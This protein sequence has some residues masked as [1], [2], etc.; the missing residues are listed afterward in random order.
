MVSQRLSALVTALNL[1]R[2]S[3]NMYPPGHSRI[4]DAVDQAHE[5]VQKSLRGRAELTFARVENT[6]AAGDIPLDPNNS[7]IRDYTRNLGAFRLVSFSLLAGVKKQELVQFHQLLSQ[8]PSDVWAKGT[9]AR[10][11]AQ[12][13]ITGIR[14]KSLDADD[15]QVTE[16]REIFFSREGKEDKKGDF[17]LDFL[18][19]SK[20]LSLT[21]ADPA[22]SLFTDPSFRARALNERRDL[23][24]KAADSYENLVREY[25][26]DLRHGNPVSAARLDALANISDMLKSL[27]PELRSQLLDSLERQVCLQPESVLAVENLKCFPR[28]L[29]QEM[30]QL[31]QERKNR[32][33]PTLILL[34]QKMTAVQRQ[35]QEAGGA[36]GDDM[37]VGSVRDLIKRE[38]YEKYVPQEYER[39]LRDAAES[40]PEAPSMEEAFPL[41]SLLKTL[42]EDLVQLRITHFSLV[43]MEEDVSDEEYRLLS[44]HLVNASMG[45]VRGGQFAFLT[46]V[47]ETLRSHTRTKESE[48]VRQR[49]L[50]AMQ[51]FTSRSMM[52]IVAPFLQ[53]GAGESA[54]VGTFLKACGEDSLS[55]LFDLYLD[56]SFTPSPF[57]L[58]ILNGFAKAAGDEA[59]RR[60]RG[61]DSA[62]IARLLTFIRETAHYNVASELKVLYDQGSRDVRRDV[63]ETL[64]QFKDPLALDLLRGIIR[65]DDWE[66]R[67]EAVHLICRYRAWDLIDEVLALLR[68]FLIRKDDASR[69]ERIIREIASTGDP[70]VA[71]HLKKLAGVRWTLSPRRLL[72]MKQL[73]R[74]VFASA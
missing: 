3:L 73:I 23:W 44:Q 50:W 34:M 51:A 55:W 21:T 46:N 17:W 25:F 74:E 33:S 62:G 70:V 32:I 19:R 59:Y 8:K 35:E 60:L 61:R 38:N 15:F 14:V 2:I 53:A 47:L 7:S 40:P 29:F 27:N 45:L 43:M 67:M 48:T 22:L 31:A 64:L 58:D 37:T 26:L 69:N 52:P 10:A 1:L 30:V 63:L 28:E 65:Q 5:L 54:D 12:A 41:Q 6:I 66:E 68:T 42:Q 36:S 9:V 4:R 13:G 39:L 71:P 49:A 20:E 56:P 16:E 11:V 72:R 57:F 18:A 24:R